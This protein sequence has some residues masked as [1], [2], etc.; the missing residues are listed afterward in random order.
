MT[1][2]QKLSVVY[3][4]PPGDSKVLEM[5]GHTFFD[6][7][8]EEVEVSDEVAE[9]IKKNPVFAPGGPPAKEQHGKAHDDDDKKHK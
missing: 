3:K 5:H 6:G 4:A 2:T 8:A 9:K 7:K 1:M